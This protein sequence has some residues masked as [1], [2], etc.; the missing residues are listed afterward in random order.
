MFAQ[1]SS[2]TMYKSMKVSYIHESV[3]LHTWLLY[4]LMLINFQTKYNI[5]NRLFERDKDNYV[6]VW[7]SNK[8]NRCLS[9]VFDHSF[10]LIA[11]SSSMTIYNSL[12]ATL[13]F[14]KVILTYWV[15]LFTPLSGDVY[16]YKS[17]ALVKQVYFIFVGYFIIQRKGNI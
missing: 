14:G 13:S 5:Q 17:K 16:Y 8:N 2:F 10:Y 12:Q 7:S 6:T 4:V 9:I 15:T 3:K 11:D 1:Q